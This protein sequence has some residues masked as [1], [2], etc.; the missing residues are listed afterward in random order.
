M[1]F[2]ILNSYGATS[3]FVLFC[4][5][6]FL[7]SIAAVAVPFDTVGKDLDGQDMGE[8]LVERRGG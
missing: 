1:V 5:V 4:G 6:A 7:G 8:E 3:V 2:P